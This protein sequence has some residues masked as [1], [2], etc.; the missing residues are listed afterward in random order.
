[1]GPEEWGTAIKVNVVEHATSGGSLLHCT[2]SV[3]FDGPI[4]TLTIMVLIPS[5]LDKETNHA[6]AIAKAKQ[7]A[8]LFIATEA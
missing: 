6:R 8:Q 2:I 7:L 5:S 4:E 1:M 3:T